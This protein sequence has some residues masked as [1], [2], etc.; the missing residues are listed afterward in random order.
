MYLTLRYKYN[1]VLGVPD[2]MIHML[3]SYR[4]DTFKDPPE[5]WWHISSINFVGKVG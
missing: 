2:L 4:S 5:I 1:T 3:S